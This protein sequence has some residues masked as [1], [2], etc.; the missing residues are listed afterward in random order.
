MSQPKIRTAI[1]KPIHIHLRLNLLRQN[2]QL[3]S[4]PTNQFHVLCIIA[5]G[6]H[7]AFFVSALEIF[8]NIFLFHVVTAICFGQLSAIDLI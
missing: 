8:A 6:V 4:Q 1:Q 3:T 2:D 5:L 7:A